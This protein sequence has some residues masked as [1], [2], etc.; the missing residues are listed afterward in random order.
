MAP[1]TAGREAEV[2]ALFQAGALAQRRL[3]R[4]V[5]L[6]LPEAHALVALVLIIPLRLRLRLASTAPSPADP[7]SATVHIG[8]TDKLPFSSP[9]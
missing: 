2:A 8:R 9:H 5:K 3:A 4:G 6:N 1:P 7:I